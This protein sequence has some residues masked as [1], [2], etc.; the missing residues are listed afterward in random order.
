VK[1]GQQEVENRQVSWI[2]YESWESWAQKK[3]DNLKP[4]MLVCILNILETF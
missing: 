3:V 2:R 1:K 4:F